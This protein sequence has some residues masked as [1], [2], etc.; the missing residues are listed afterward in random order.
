MGRAN[1]VADAAGLANPKLKPVVDAAVVAGVPAQTDKQIL[2]YRKCVS[3]Q[4]QSGSLKDGVC[5]LLQ[6]EQGSMYLYVH[7]KVT[8]KRWDE[9]RVHT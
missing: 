5:L 1:G 4:F 9:I 8:Y 2:F 3:Y 7:E 6:L